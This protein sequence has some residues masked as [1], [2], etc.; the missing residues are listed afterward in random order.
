MLELVEKAD[1]GS[2]IADTVTLSFELRQKSRQ[3]VRLDSGQTAALLLPPGTV[4]ADGDRLRA[5]DGTTIGVCAAIE[6]VSTARSDDPR[7]L[8]RACYHLGNRHVRLEIGA[9]WVRY[10]PDH[11][12]DDMVRALG[13]AVAHESARFEPERG[14]Y[15]RHAQAHDDGAFAQESHHHH[16]ASH[17]H[18]H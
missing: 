3:R 16:H 1:H 9:G 14:A 6:T 8:A 13:L 12:L 18:R 4:L 17:G 7:H 5:S 10:Q 15:H 2:T 11:V